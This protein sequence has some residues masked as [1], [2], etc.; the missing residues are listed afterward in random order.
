VQVDVSAATA[1]VRGTAKFEDLANAVKNVGF[2]ATHA[3][4]T[5]TSL[6]TNCCSNNKSDSEVL[7]MSDSCCEA[8]GQ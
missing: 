7:T 1:Q 8:K 3:V 2:T 4:E 5:D 6:G